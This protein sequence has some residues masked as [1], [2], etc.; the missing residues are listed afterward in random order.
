MKQAQGELRYWKGDGR[1]ENDSG[2]KGES[3]LANAFA[4]V[5]D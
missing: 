3:L 5:H 1:E 2:E 4:D